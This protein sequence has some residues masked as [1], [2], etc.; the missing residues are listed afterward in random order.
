MQQ[1][2]ITLRH[3]VLSSHIGCGDNVCFRYSSCVVSWIWYLTT[4]VGCT[5]TAS[6]IPVMRV[7][8]FSLCELWPGALGIDTCHPFDRSGTFLLTQHHIK[9]NHHDSQLVYM[10][11]SIL[12]GWMISRYKFRVVVILSTICLG[13]MPGVNNIVNKWFICIDSIGVTSAALMH[14]PF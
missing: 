11:L 9:Q 6:F 5:Y 7:L 4:M 3:L 10:H 12:I 1:I 14:V 8:A 13:Q 2:D